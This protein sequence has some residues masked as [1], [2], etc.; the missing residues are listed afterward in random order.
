VIEGRDIAYLLAY[1]DPVSQLYLENIDLTF[2][3]S[4]QT[5]KNIVVL[6]S[7]SFHFH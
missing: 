5:L 6:L 1:H 7:E 3:N 2:F 4:K